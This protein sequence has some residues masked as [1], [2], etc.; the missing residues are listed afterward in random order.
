M[1]TE[2]ACQAGHPLKADETVCP[3]CGTLPQGKL[4]PPTSMVLPT[5]PGFEILQELGRGGMGVVYQARQVSLNR[6]VALKMILDVQRSVSTTRMVQGI[7]S[8]PPESAT[9]LV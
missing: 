6:I 2:F 3:I 4:T 7:A 1:E 9:P 5:I 8:L